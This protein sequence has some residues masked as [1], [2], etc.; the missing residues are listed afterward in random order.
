MTPAAPGEGVSVTKESFQRMSADSK[1]DVLYD[2]I[3]SLHSRETAKENACDKRQEGCEKRFKGL[4]NRKIRDMSLSSAAGLIGGWLAV[5]T[6]KYFLPGLVIGFALYLLAAC[7][8]VKITA[9]KGS[10][11]NVDAHKQVTVSTE[12]NIPPTLL[13]M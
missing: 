8:T 2:Y 6:K 13:G 4:E 7:T 10:I 11:V 5:M 3:V 9:E 1:L 12:A